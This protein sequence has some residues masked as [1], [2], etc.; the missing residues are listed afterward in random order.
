MIN[1]RNMIHMQFISTRYFFKVNLNNVD[2]KFGDMS[3][4][5]SHKV[6]YS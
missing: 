4:A 3:P 2:N 5:R 6:D 1:I